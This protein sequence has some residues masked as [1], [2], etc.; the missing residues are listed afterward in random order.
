MLRDAFS[1]VLEL[2]TDQY[3]YVTA[4]QAR[5]AGVHPMTLVM[6]AKRA[7]IERVDHGL[8]RVP[9]VPPHRLAEYRGAT[10]WPF[11]RTGVLS[12]ETALE[13]LELSDVNPDRIHL[14]LPKA[15]RIRRAIPRRYVIHHADLSV[16]DV[17]MHEGVP[18]TTATRAICDCLTAGV[19]PTLLH[20]AIQDGERAG[21]LTASK[22]EELRLLVDGLYTPMGANGPRHLGKRLDG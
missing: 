2:A 21:Y 17:T 12:H 4:E 1:T 11:G 16:A 14:T 3:G 5:Q 19:R 8:Y 18:I 6:M 13:L 10:L 22:G 15:F 20:Q 9:A 7:T